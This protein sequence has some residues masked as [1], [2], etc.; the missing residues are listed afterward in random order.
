MCSDFIIFAIN[1]FFCKNIYFIYLELIYF[2]IFS[3]SI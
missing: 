3:T 2:M 1:V